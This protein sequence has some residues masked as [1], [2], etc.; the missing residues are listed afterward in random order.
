[1][2]TIAFLA[3]MV[4]PCFV[5]A[6]PKG[7][8]GS[9]GYQGST[10]FHPVF[11][12]G[13]SKELA[14]GGAHQLLS[15]VQVGAYFHSRMHTGLYAGPYTEW[16]CTAPRGFQFGM[17]LPLGYLR[18]FIPQVYGTGPSGE[19]QFQPMAGN[20]YFFLMPGFRL[21]RKTKRGGLIESWYVKNKLMI[22][23]PHAFGPGFRYF[24][25]I[26]ITHRLQS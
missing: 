17:D 25:E 19:V 23:T 13:V 21:G 12:I 8:Y 11:S 10:I 15:G 7:Y 2:K 5:F 3:V 6:Q 18:T 4:L 22:I 16:L 9:L 20:G 1:M 14:S 24:L 26:G